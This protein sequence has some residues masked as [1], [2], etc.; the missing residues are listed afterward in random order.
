MRSWMQQSQTG[1][2]GEL[3][4]RLLTGAT[5]PA[6]FLTTEAASNNGQPP[7]LP[8]SKSLHHYNSFI[9]PRIT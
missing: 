5:P 9:K 3:F 8:L 4:E 2:R 7:P 6:P 1:A